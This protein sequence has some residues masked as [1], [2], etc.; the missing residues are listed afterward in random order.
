M[1]YECI[2]FQI[3]EL[4]PK[5][6]YHDRGDKAWALLDDRLLK[7]ADFLRARFG[8][9]TVNDW[10]WGG[11]NQW[12][13][14]RTSDSPYYRP[15]SQHSFGRALDLIFHEA[16]CEDVRSWLK[17]NVEEWTNLGIVWSITLEEGVGWL[18][19]DVRNGPEGYNSF[20]V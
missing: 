15:Y 10:W 13:G 8:P 5:D 4:V 12:R 11:S 16:N 1:T 18:H 7:F 14:L 20:K 17:N 19:I 6:V 2:N 9:A 3:Y